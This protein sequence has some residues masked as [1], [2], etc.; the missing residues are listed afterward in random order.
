MGRCSGSPPVRHR[1]V[2]RHRRWVR[3]FSIGVWRVGGQRQLHQGGRTWVTQTR[4]SRRW[5]AISNVPSRRRAARRRTL[6]VP[7]TSGPA[8]RHKLPDERGV[9]AVTSGSRQQMLALLERQN[10][11]IDKQQRQL[12]IL[13]LKVDTLTWAVAATSGRPRH[14]PRSM[15]ATPEILAI[16]ETGSI[17]PRVSDVIITKRRR[18]PGNFRTRSCVVCNRPYPP[19]GPYQKVC[20][21][22]GCASHGK[23]PQQRKRLIQMAAAGYRW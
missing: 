14:R 15:A 6:R 10:Q 18:E 12:A 8:R 4:G 7:P 17:P 9:A 13:K 22:E 23:S 2:W 20:M 3:K 16:P 5:I 1:E 21:M 19:R 11:L